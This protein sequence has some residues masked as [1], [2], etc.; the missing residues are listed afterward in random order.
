MRGIRAAELDAAGS[1]KS[2]RYIDYREPRRGNATGGVTDGVT[3][4]G[5][6]L[7]DDRKATMKN[8]AGPPG[9]GVS[10][11]FLELFRMMLD[12]FFWPIRLAV[13]IFPIRGV[14]CCGSVGLLHWRMS[15][16]LLHLELA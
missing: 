15:S 12:L 7:G 4:G 5:A 13:S 10:E 14:P 6:E 16:P 2:R 8:V 11:N 9:A 1:S 3:G